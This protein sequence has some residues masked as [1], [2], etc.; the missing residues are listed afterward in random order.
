MNVHPTSQKSHTARDF[1]CE[2]PLRGALSWW[3]PWAAPVA[4]EIQRKQADRC[5]P[6]SRRSRD[7]HGKE[8]PPAGCVP[9][10]LRTLSRYYPK[11]AR[12]TSVTPMKPKR[13]EMSNR[14]PIRIPGTREIL[15]PRRRSSVTDN[16][17][18][19]SIPHVDD[20]ARSDASAK[21]NIV[22]FIG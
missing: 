9:N 17:K 15:M 20:T 10:R 7:L 2:P 11:V 4:G 5:G 3:Y 22:D 16:L 18:P 19:R 21:H 1:G 6:P 13:L 8:W 14:I 12:P